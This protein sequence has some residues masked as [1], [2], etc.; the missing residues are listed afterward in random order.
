MADGLRETSGNY[1]NLTQG[2]Q[3][4]GASE[5]PFMRE[6]TKP[7]YIHYLNEN[8]NNPALMNANAPASDGLTDNATLYATPQAHVV[9]YTPR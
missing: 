9:D 3:A 8:L 5:Q 2:W 4:F 6:L 7:D 1:N